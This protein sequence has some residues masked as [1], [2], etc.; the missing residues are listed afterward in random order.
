MAEVQ[1]GTKP[2]PATVLT[3]FETPL[4]RSAAQALARAGHRLC[5]LRGDGAP[6]DQGL[7]ELPGHDRL[8]HQGIAAARGGAQRRGYLDQDGVA[9]IGFDRGQELADFEV[10]HGSAL[11]P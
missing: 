6:A 9:A 7:S 11:S 4:G 5:V 3:G 2:A 8:K 10:N 1:T